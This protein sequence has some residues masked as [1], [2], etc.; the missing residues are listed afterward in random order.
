MRNARAVIL[1]EK[2][3]GVPLSSEMKM[4]MGTNQN[5]VTFEGMKAWRAKFADAETKYKRTGEANAARR[6]SEVRRALT[7]DMYSMAQEGD[8]LRAGPPRT[9]YQSCA[10]QPRKALSHYLVNSLPMM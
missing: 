3:A 1:A 8:L 10:Y 7:D 2:S 4:L 6:A 5:G 9:T